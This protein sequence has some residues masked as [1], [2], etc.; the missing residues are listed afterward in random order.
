[1]RMEQSFGRKN[2]PS[3]ALCSYGMSLLRTEL[4]VGVILDGEAWLR[5]AGTNCGS[6][7]TNSPLKA[8]GG[9]CDIPTGLP[10]LTHGPHSSGLAPSVDG[11]SDGS[12]A[13]WVLGHGLI[14]AW[15]NAP[16]C[17]AGGQ[18]AVPRPCRGVEW[19]FAGGDR[20][21]RSGQ[22]GWLPGRGGV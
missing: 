6:L 19:A 10:V 2:P 7:F 8:P 1:M 13:V 3:W 5:S 16:M 21:L 22:S 17:M 15:G 20:C 14:R 18:R 11:R 9:P 12:M 4:E